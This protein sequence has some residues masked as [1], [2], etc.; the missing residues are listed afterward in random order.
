M[1]TEEPLV[2]DTTD[3]AT[4]GPLLGDDLDAALARLTERVNAALAY[5]GGTHLF[6]DVAAGL[7]EG[8]MQLWVRGD[9]YVVSEL[10]DYPQRRVFNVFL[11][12]G[13]T[14]DIIAMY[15][16]LAVWAREWGCDVAHATGRPGWTRALEAQG[17]VPTWVA[18]QK[19]L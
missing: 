8:T 7:H 14:E 15:E 6:E 11:A 19:E 18:L 2:K 9:S 17:W 13:H 4:V 12:G 10:I 5:S 16:P 3:I 1:D